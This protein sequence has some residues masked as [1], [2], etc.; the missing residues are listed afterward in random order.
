MIEVRTH[1][2]GVEYLHPNAIARITVAS[3]SSQ[4]HGIRSIIRTFDGAVIE[5]SDDADYL[6]RMIAAAPKPEGK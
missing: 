1:S 6:I 4:W 3:A 5:S 2:G